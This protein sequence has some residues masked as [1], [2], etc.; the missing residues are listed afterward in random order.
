MLQERGGAVGAMDERYCIDN[1]AMIAYVGLLMFQ[2]GYR[3]NIQ[4]TFFTQSYR[5]DEVDVIWRD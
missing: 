1:G 3:D 5:T 2:K 4:N